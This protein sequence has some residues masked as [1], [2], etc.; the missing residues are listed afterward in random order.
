MSAECLFTRLVREKKDNIKKI[1]GADSDIVEKVVM[2]RRLARDI[3]RKYFNIINY[4]SL[5]DFYKDYENGKSP[6]VELEG[7]G[8]RSKDLIILNECPSAPLFPDFKE[9]GEFPEYWTK[10]PQL[11]M[12]KFKNE[13][14][15]HPLCIVHQT[16]RDL[17]ASQI[18]KGK[19]VVHSIGVA[20]RS[21]ATGKVVYSEFGLSSSIAT[22]EDIDKVIDGFACA[23]H[24]I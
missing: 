2:L 9:D 21:G 6:L 20:C 13:A 15:L 11:F 3:A 18:P 14:I 23:F 8:F 12:E 16:C 10:L 1:L 17:L 24:L 4:K 19:G 5:E 7:D 22:K